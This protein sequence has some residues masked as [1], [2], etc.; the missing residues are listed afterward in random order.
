MAGYYYYNED[1]DYLED[2]KAGKGIPPIPPIEFKKT[3]LCKRNNHHFV[4][5]SKGNFIYCTKCG[6]IKN[7]K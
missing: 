4:E 3:E 7:V 2:I 5:H 1:V 6:L